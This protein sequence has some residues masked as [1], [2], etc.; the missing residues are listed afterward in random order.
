MVMADRA[1]IFDSDPLRVVVIGGGAAGFFG[2]IACAR[3]NPTAQVVVL[4][5]G[6]QFLSKVLISG[7]GRCNVTHACFEPSQL[8]QSYPRGHRA[9]RGPFSRF[10]PQ[11]TIAWFAA[12]GVLLKIEPD[13]RMFPTTDRSSTIADCLLR[14]A[15]RSGVELRLRAPVSD[16]RHDG[17]E[18]AVQLRSG[19][20]LWADRVLL[21]TGSQPSAYRWA[22]ALGHPIVPPVP[23]LFTLAIRDPRLDTLAGLS[24]KRGRVRL[25]LPND[26]SSKRR[27]PPLEQIGPVLITHW[28]LS[29]PAVLKLSAWGARSLHDTRYRATLQVNWLGEESVDTARDRLRLLKQANA[30][31]AVSTSGPP[32]LPKRLWQQL[33]FAVGVAPDTRWADLPKGPI[34]L[35]VRELVQGEFQITGK[36]VF[37]EEFVTCGGVDLKSVDFKTLESRHCPGLYFAGEILDIDGITGGFN[38]QSAWSTG[39]IAGR[40]IAMSDRTA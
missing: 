31:R 37:K 26:G 35:L 40:A 3:S 25:L 33:V 11:D 6:P 15:T 7:G 20:V 5:A 27:Q 21:A 13:G 14:A 30:K 12:E 8:V 16:L 32:E 10:Q 19:Q 22:A 38:F 34:E 28:G 24:V 23:S 17:R 1:A 39:W 9:L 2:A 29:G 18:F 4:E 36:G